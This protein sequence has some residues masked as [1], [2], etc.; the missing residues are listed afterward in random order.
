MDGTCGLLQILCPNLHDYFCSSSSS[1]VVIHRFIPQFVCTFH[2]HYVSCRMHACNTTN[3]FH[4]ETFN[5][6]TVP[7]IDTQ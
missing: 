6:V 2:R 5:V 7:N 3:I 1:C 4:F